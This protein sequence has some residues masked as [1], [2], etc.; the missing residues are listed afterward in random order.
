M[1]RTLKNAW[2]TK[3]IRSK[4]LFTLLILLIYRIGTVIPV[5]FVEANSFAQSLDGTILQYMDTLSG[6]ALGSMT[7][8]ALGVQ[9]YINASIIIQLLAVVFPKLGELAKNDKKKMNFITRIVTMILAVVTAIG[10]YFILRNGNASMGVTSFLTNAAF[11]GDMQWLYAIV[12]IMCYVAGAAIIMWLA[13]RINEKGIGNGISLILFAN[14]V[15]AVPSFVYNLAAFAIDTYSYPEKTWLYALLSTLFAVLLVVG[16]LA[17]IG[18]VIWFTGS[19]RRI[20]VQ[21]AKKVVG[22]KMYGGQNSSLPIKLN[23]TGVMPIIFAS[24]IVSFFP[25]LFQILESAGALK[26]G[27]FWAGFAKVVGTDGAVYPIL[28][29]LLVIGFAYFYSQISF[30]P[31]EVANNL[32]KQGGAIPGIRQGRPTSDYI[33]KILNKITFAGALFLAVI[34]VLPIVIGPHALKYF[35]EWVCEGAYLEV[36]KQS[37]ALESLYRAYYIEPAA[38]SLTNIFTFSGTTL[39]IVVGVAIETFRELEAQLTMRNYKGFL[40]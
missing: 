16:L 36:F 15:A 39:L 3:E 13:E 31:I 30:N 12:I 33:K 24:S 27:G 9:P 38:A 18:L 26:A 17:L 6:G 7:L 23:M 28:M 5:P 1:L 34:A 19:E 22:R 25:T 20:P 37:P 2:N 40:N 14:I 35:Y 8:F 32:K 11:E 21:Y 10:Y 4:I 29:F